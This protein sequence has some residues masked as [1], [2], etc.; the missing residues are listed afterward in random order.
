MQPH[1]QVKDD[2]LNLNPDYIVED[3]SGIRMDYQQGILRKF[4][5]HKLFHYVGEE[6]TNLERISFTNTDPGHPLM[7]LYADQAEVRNKGENVY[8]TGN[9]TAIRGTDDEKGRITLVTG[10]LHLIPNQSLA[11]TDRP[12]AISRFNTAIEATGLEFDNRAG[13][14]QLLSSVKAVNMK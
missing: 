9:V 11:K 3:L 1:E 13:T 2:S 14:I 7:R 6:L 5:A 4:T 10:F 8:L 12:V